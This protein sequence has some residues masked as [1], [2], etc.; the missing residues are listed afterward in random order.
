M[1]EP[2]LVNA[3]HGTTVQ[4]FPLTTADMCNVTSGTAIVTLVRCVA[5]GTIAV[6]FPDSTQANITMVE[7]DDYAFPGGASISVSSGTF[8]LA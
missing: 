7:G 2:K 5:D 4:A 8:H 3:K 6:T 1:S